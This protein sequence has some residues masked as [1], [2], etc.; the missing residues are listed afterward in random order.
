MPADPRRRQAGRDL[1]VEARGRG[2]KDDIRDRLPRGAAT[3]NG[4]KVALVGAGPA[5]LTVAN[6]LMPLGYD[7]TIF[8]KLPRPGG[9]MRITSASGCP[10]RLDEEIG[11]IVD[12]GVNVRYDSPVESLGVCSTRRNSTRCSSGAGRRKARSSRFPAARHRSD[13]HRHRVARIDSLR[14]RRLVGKRVPSSALA[15][16]RWT[17]PVGEAARRDR[18]QGHRAQDPQYFKASPWELE[19]AEEERVEIVENL[20]PIRF[21]VENGTLTGMESEQFKSARSTAARTGS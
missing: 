12:M 2:S 19:D 21:I 11:Y 15:T 13:L 14:L 8:E 5:S 18:R 9:L 1:P 3:K 17:V 7:V 20:Q 6:D 16:R 10:R 4:K